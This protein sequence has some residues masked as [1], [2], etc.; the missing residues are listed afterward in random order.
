M[1]Y[2]DVLEYFGTQVKIAAA[3]E[4]TQGSVSAWDG[5]IPPLRQLQIQQV[6][7]GKLKAD[8]DVFTRKPARSA[9]EAV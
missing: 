9:Q 7:R 3:L 8:A 4:M 5:S 2:D 6:T 1:T